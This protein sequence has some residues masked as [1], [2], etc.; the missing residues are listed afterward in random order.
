MNQSPETIPPKLTLTR[1]SLLKTT[2]LGIA[3]AFALHWNQDEMLKSPIAYAQA[4]PC[5]EPNDTF[6]TACYIGPGAPATGYISSVDD[7]D[8]YRFEALDFGVDAHVELTTK[9]APYRLNIADWRG[10]ILTSTKDQTD[11]TLGP[12]GS[13][14]IFVDSET[15]EFDPNNPYVLS[16]QL[17][18]PGYTIPD[19]M[20]ASDFHPGSEGKEQAFTGETDLAR[21]VNEKGRYT[22][23]MKAG[24]TAEDP[25]W[26]AGWW[27]P[28]FSDFTMT[29][30]SRIEDGSTDPT[31]NGLVVFFRSNLKGP[32][33]TYSG[34]FLQVNGAGH[35]RLGM[36]ENGRYTNLTRW[37]TGPDDF[38]PGE[39]SR[40]VVRA[41]GSDILININGWDIHN[42]K[43][44]RLK[45]GNFA[46]GA[47][48]WAD[49]ETIHFD[50]ILVTTPSEG[51]NPN[52]FANLRKRLSAT[53]IISKKEKNSFQVQVSNPSNLP[54]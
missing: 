5:P 3:G 10:R 12:P 41:A 42:L 43:N 36:Y 44:D 53:T 33:A 9:P 8:A 19:R 31:D 23:N 50:N 27:G 34:Y 35:S 46:F 29:V 51:L 14:Y 22:V 54:A 40:T 7:I 48:N 39:A 4:D 21:F 24:G 37:T 16:R 2:A 15:G 11:L 38:S 45:S 25:S 13:Y 28:Q 6:Q 1:R 32:E 26:A 47:I 17:T 18:Y 30:D 49:P 20:Y 52:L